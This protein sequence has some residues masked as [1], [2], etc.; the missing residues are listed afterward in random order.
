MIIL[1]FF[2]FHFTKITHIRHVCCLTFINTELRLLTSANMREVTSE[3]MYT[4]CVFLKHVLLRIFHAIVILRY[5]WTIL[6]KFS[7]KHS[8]LQH[9]CSVHC[10][11][12]SRMEYCSELRYNLIIPKQQIC[13]CCLQL[14]YQAGKPGHIFKV[15]SVVWK[16]SQILL[17]WHESK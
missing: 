9:L 17:G 8:Y 15:T 5:Y 3:P 4:S 2:C 16:E 1:L 6:S 11:L 10:H 13:E 14:H 12:Q 7:H